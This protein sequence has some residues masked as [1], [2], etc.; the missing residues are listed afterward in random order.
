MEI[1]ACIVIALLS[2]A[3]LYAQ[4][5]A[6]ASVP[7]PKPEA[8]QSQASP[9]APKA[10]P[11]AAQSQTPPPFV[12]GVLKPVAAVRRFSAGATL[13]VMGLT[14]VKKR[15]IN[16]VTSSPVVDAL[17]STINASQRIG[18]GVTA[19]VAITDRFAVNGSL[20]MKKLGY[21]M[22]SDIIEGNDPTTQIHTSRHEDT[23]ARL[24]DLPVVVRYYGKD[25]FDP[26]ARWFVEGG[27]ALRRVSN[28]RTTTDTVVGS[29]NLT[30]DF[31]AAKPDRRTIR[32]LV[33]GFG[34]QLIDPFGIRVVPEVRY[35]RWAGQIFNSLSTGTRRDQ[36]EAM[37][38]LG[39]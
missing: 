29:G 21:Q 15:D 4:N 3:S 37:I 5:Q 24:F 25:R 32:G 18:F 10:K 30:Y 20:F 13:T 23:R 22:T 36:V 11:E 35:T 2:S 19:Q 16:T 6:P 28:I 38:S 1:K 17:Y 31:T 27:A 34:V 14:T 39:F 12:P 33:A 8:S 9:A 26:G 7:Q